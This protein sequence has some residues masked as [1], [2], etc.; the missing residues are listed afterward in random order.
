MLIEF[1]EKGR[2]KGEKGREGERKIID[3]I[4]KHAL[5]R[6][7]TCNLL[8]SE[9]NFLRIPTGLPTFSVWTFRDILPSENLFLFLKRPDPP[10]P[11]L[12]HYL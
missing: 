2:K 11:P 1:R 6:N 12:P 3:V 9:L 10:P 8:S 4:K 7:Q 5:T